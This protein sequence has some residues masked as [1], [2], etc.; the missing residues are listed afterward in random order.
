M[1]LQSIT[2]SEVK[3]RKCFKPEVGHLPETMALLFRFLKSTNV[4]E[5]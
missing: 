4:P 3:K 5:L 1:D 2:Q